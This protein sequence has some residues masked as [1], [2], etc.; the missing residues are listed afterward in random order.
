MEENY[1]Y[2]IEI[3]D[4][5]FEYDRYYLTLEQNP[6][7][8]LFINNY[9][10]N[11]DQNKKIPN[12][13]ISD[14]T[15]YTV[16][17]KFSIDK[18]STPVLFQILNIDYKVLS[19][20]EEK[21]KEII[22]INEIPEEEE[23]NIIN[24]NIKLSPTKKELYLKSKNSKELTLNIKSY[25]TKKIV[26]SFN[27]RYPLFP[28]FFSFLGEKPETF[29]ILQYPCILLQYEAG[30]NRIS[31][32]KTQ[33]NNKEDNA[34]L[35]S[36]YYALKKIIIAEKDDEFFDEE[37][38]FAISNEGNK[39]K[40]LLEH[41]FTKRQKPMKQKNKN[42]INLQSILEIKGL[43]D[44][45]LSTLKEK[46]EELNKKKKELKKLSDKR[47]AI[48]NQKK[49]IF[50]YEKKI[51]FNKSSWNRLVTLKEILNKINTY[52]T[53]VILLKEKKISQAYEDIEKYKKDLA[54]KNNKKIPSLQKI[55]QGLQISNFFLIK[56]AIYEITSLFFNKNINRYNAFPSFYK[57]SI[58]ELNQNKI[59]VLDF[60]YSNSKEVSLMFGNIIYLLTYISK[61]FDIIFPFALYYNGA[62]SVSF[63]NMNS[64]N[65]GVDLY[66][67]E[68]EDENDIYLKMEIISKMI[69]DTI[70]FF[71]AKKI[72][73]DKF[74]ID[75]IN[76]KKKKKKCN[77]YTLF[78]KLNQLFKDILGYNQI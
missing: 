62:K 38:D 25:T 42:Y 61:K 13:S 53:E 43:Y 33:K 54:E 22:N 66:L 69:Y 68:N 58:S 74:K 63:I 39:N 23:E 14:I 78:V 77:M 51:E 31:N 10:I 7:E 5:N 37:I 6:K 46:K 50:S 26:F 17:P 73:S 8:F 55:N 45:T 75:D 3:R 24:E 60:Y 20:K 11:I 65:F 2:S 71:Y 1:F 40:N 19:K 70:M 27:I 56:H 29:K 16:V 72:C 15:P 36:G 32:T 64:N 67:K 34:I 76:N 59:K 12:D 49:E 28:D 57:L 47:K 4:L 30:L 21:D 35:K 44:S 9:K 41:L 52:T 48:M 18:I